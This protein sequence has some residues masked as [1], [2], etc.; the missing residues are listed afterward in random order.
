MPMTRDVG[1]L[2]PS[3]ICEQSAVLSAQLMRKQDV[4]NTHTDDAEAF[5]EK[6]EAVIVQASCTRRCLAATCRAR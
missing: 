3:W 5:V 1:A 6:R 2:L 4:R